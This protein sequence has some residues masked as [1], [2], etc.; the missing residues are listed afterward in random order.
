[1][2]QMAAWLSV[3]IA[4]SCRAPFRPAYSCAICSAKL[5]PYSS[6]AYTVDA[7][8]RPMCTDRVCCVSGHSAAEPISPSMPLPSVYM[9]RLLSFARSLSCLSRALSAVG[10][11]Y[12][13]GPCLQG[14]VRKHG[15]CSCLSKSWVR[16]LIMSLCTFS[17]ELMCLIQVLSAA[18]GSAVLV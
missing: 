16:L 14:G 11:M 7:V 12:V 3:Y 4:T 6:A 10:S 18:V 2:D 8:S 15:I 1:M 17:Q 13:V 5:I 9:L